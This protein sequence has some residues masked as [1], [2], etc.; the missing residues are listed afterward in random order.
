MVVANGLPQGTISHGAT[1]TFLW[2]ERYPMASYLAE[3][4]IGHFVEQRSSGPAG[5]PIL[6]FVPPSAAA[7]AAGVF[8][9]LPRMIAY[10]ESILG[11]YPFEAYGGIVAD[12]NLSY[13]LETQTRTLYG[14][15]ILRYIQDRAQEGI[16]HEL[17]H[18]WFGDSVS[19]KTWQDIWLNEGFATYMSWLW[20]EYIHDRAYLESLMRSQY[21]YLLEAP[22]FNTLLTHPELTGPRV[23]QIMQAILRVQGQS[24]S[25]A[26]ILQGM[27]L[28]AADEVTSIRA[29]GF[30]GVHPGSAD[31]RGFQESARSSAPAGPPRD[32]L[33]PSSVYN[34]GAMA[35]QALRLRVGDP[36]FFRILRTYYARYRYANA[37]T[38][39][40]I[41]VADAVS[42]QNLTSF[43]QTW[44]YAPATPPMPALLPTQ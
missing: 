21:G 22:Y 16:A 36:T 23:L 35:L 13:A 4:A 1:T 26:Q 38:A 41:A 8:K 6:T 31:A 3:V 9:P 7:Q 17:A 29:L 27:G 43:F 25:T 42:S 10:F 39:D 33:F 20:L 18:Q 5:L 30:F 12:T 24:M 40:F 19:V 37:D 11:S 2:Q 28:T 15:T 44:L 14:W 34:R 32:D